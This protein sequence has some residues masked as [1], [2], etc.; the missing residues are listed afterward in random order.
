[1][2]KN[3]ILR[4]LLIAA[5]ASMMTFALTGCGG[6]PPWVNPKQ[7]PKPSWLPSSPKR[8]TSTDRARTGAFPAQGRLH[9]DRWRCQLLRR[10]DSQSWRQELRADQRIH[11]RRQVSN[12]LITPNK[13][14]SQPARPT[15][16]A[17]SAEEIPP[18]RHQIAV[19]T[20]APTHGLI[21]LDANWVQS[22]RTVVTCRKAH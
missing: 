21:S 2:K 3:V 14:P 7:K 22:K 1:M 4:A 15:A 8:A 17:F 12:V 9:S 20:T 16:R 18:Q 19:F 11:Y 13:R 5:V 6:S 10:Q